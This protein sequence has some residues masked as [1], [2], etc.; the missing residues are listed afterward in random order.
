MNSLQIYQWVCQWKNFENR[1]TFAEVMGKSLVS[2]FF[3][4]TV[5]IFIWNVL[6][7]TVIRYNTVVEKTKPSWIITEIYAPYFHILSWLCAIARCNFISAQFD[8]LHICFGDQKLLMVCFGYA[9]CAVL[10]WYAGLQWLLWLTDIHIQELELDVNE[11]V[12]LEQH[13]WH[14]RTL[15]TLSKNRLVIH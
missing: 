3:W 9:V 12:G 10:Y 1:L 2:C 14:G 7:S 11:T 8:K 15:F 5:Y 6:W 13:I 4:D